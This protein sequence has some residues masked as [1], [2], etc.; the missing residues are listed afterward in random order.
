MFGTSGNDYHCF[1][2][3]LVPS[4]FRDAQSSSRAKELCFLGLISPLPVSLGAD[5]GDG[6]SIHFPLL[7]DSPDDC[8]FTPHNTRLDNEPRMEVTHG[9]A[10]RRHS[11]PQTL[12]FS[13]P[14]TA[15]LS[16]R[17]QSTIGS[18]PRA[19]WNRALHPHPR[20]DRITW[21]EP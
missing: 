3:I 17:G 20:M 12:H 21:Y 13:F 9:T 4:Q 1:N 15:A 14:N 6:S 19:A 5:V 16:S 11:Q 8:I 2:M 10:G 7:P 18:W